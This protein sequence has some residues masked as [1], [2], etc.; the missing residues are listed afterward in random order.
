[1]SRKRSS[2][3]RNSRVRMAKFSAASRMRGW[4]PAAGGAPLGLEPGVLSVS[5]RLSA[6]REATTAGPDWESWAQRWTNSFRW[7]S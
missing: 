5:A 6:R 3:S 7:S 1:M 4:S 2:R